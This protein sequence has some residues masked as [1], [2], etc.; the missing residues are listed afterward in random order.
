MHT[1]KISE[2]D[3]PSQESDIFWM[4]KDITGQELAEPFGS[5]KRKALFIKS[6]VLLQ[7]C[8]TLRQS[9]VRLTGLWPS[10]TTSR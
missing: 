2:K 8:S 1:S 4:K 7:T 5:N 9:M 6:I 10:E 3:I